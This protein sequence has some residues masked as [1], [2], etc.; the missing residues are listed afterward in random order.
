M[1]T[2]ETEVSDVLWHTRDGD[3]EQAIRD[4]PRDSIWPLGAADNRYSLGAERHAITYQS[5]RLRRS[6]ALVD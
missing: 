2:S 1:E 4:D 5:R 6:S 3:A